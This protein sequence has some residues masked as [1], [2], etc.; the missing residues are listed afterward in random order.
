MRRGCL[1]REVNPGGE[2]ECQEFYYTIFFQ[3]DLKGF[4]WH[5]YF[6]GAS[7]QAGKPV[8]LNLSF[9]FFDKDFSFTLLI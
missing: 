2:G 3:I 4:G 8:L 7:A 6:T 1:V 5:R 9:L